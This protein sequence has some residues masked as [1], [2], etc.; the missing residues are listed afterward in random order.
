MPLISFSTSGSLVDRL[1]CTE[2]FFFFGFLCLL[3]GCVFYSVFGCYLRSAAFSAFFVS[4]S[5]PAMR[6]N[7]RFYPRLAGP[8]TDD[9]PFALHR[10]P[11]ASRMLWPTL[12]IIVEHPT[13]DLPTHVHMQPCAREVLFHSFIYLVIYRQSDLES[14]L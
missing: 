6:G 1:S 7:P 14:R 5:V 13:Y 11:S 10:L 4:S 2:F 9:S 12:Y 8:Q 3:F